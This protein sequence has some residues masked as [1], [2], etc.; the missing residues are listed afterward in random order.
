MLNMMVHISA[1]LLLNSLVQSRF[2]F[3]FR[4]GVRRTFLTAVFVL[5]RVCGYNGVVGIG[6]EQVLRRQILQLQFLCTRR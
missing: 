5:A 2:V 1:F 6:D 4:I 3:F